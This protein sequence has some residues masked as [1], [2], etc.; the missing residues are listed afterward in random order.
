MNFKKV[1]DSELVSLLAGK[2]ETANSA[3]MEIYAR[4]SKKV[5][6]Y[7]KKSH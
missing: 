3:Y 6:I 4:Y 1:D 7:C 2:E 5:Y